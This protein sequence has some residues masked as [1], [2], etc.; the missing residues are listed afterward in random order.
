M[1]FSIFYF[2]IFFNI[3]QHFISNI[4]FSKT[5]KRP[6]FLYI[7]I[8]KFSCSTY[9]QSIQHIYPVQL[10]W[11]YYSFVLNYYRY[12]IWSNACLQLPNIFDGSITKTFD[13]S[14]SPYNTLCIFA[15]IILNACIKFLNYSLLGIEGYSSAF[16][17]LW[18]L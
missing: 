13:G 3:S 7:Y 4:L 8:S 15:Y 16:L 10:L 14:I 12:F 17:I 18:Y 9:C 6:L 5:F 1:F 2:S 11:N